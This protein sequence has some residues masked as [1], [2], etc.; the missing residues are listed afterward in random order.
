MWEFLPGTAYQAD[1]GPLRRDHPAVGWTP[2]AV[3]A[4]RQ[5]R[6]GG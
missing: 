2:F 5:F 4:Q 1:I 6:T 3:G